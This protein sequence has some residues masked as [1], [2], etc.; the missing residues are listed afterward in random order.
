MKLTGEDLKQITDS[1]LDRLAA[2]QLLSFTKRLLT[3]SKELMD[4]LNQNPNNSSR[5]P[6]SAAPWESQSN[7]NQLENVDDSENPVVDDDQPN[8]NKDDIADKEEEIVSKKNSH[9]EVNNTTLSDEKSLCASIDSQSTLPP[10][11]NKRSAGKQIGAPGFGR[12]QEFPITSVMYHYISC[13]ALCSAEQ[14]LNSQTAWTA[15]C[16][17]DIAELIS[18]Q[19]GIIVTNTKHVFYETNC[20]CGHHNKTKPHVVSPDVNWSNTNISEWRLIGPRL[21]AMIVLLSK[22]YRNS[23]RLIREFLLEFL[24]IELSVGAIDQTIREAGRCVAPLEAQLIEAL[25]K[26]ALVYVDET[27]WKQSGKLFWLWVF[28]AAT[29]A[30][31]A[32]GKRNRTILLNFLLNGAFNG[33]LMSDGWFV[34]RDY[35]NRLRCWAHLIRKARGLAESHNCEI[36]DVGKKMLALFIKFQNAIYDMRDKILQNINSVSLTIQLAN[37][38]EELKALCVAYQECKHDKLKAFSRELLHDWDIIFR[39]LHDP[40]LPL[41]NNEAER[42]LRHWVIDRR[43]SHGTRTPEGT[44]TFSLLA[45]VIATCRIR[46]APIW[47]YLTSVIAAA[48]VGSQLPV[49]PIMQA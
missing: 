42:M 46:G 7:S 13:C 37:E 28:K 25:E 41:T 14:T 38:I 18:G 34:Y 1:S 45:S 4:R 5:P 31:F 15:F 27:S 47:N 17:L 30:F 11:E 49:L 3:Y 26:S 24:G 40:L 33:V 20:A 6:S 32:V 44:R 36:S 19:A 10:P 39:Q 12:A 2:E 8:D 43:L 22:R 21:A 29:V 9:S 16:S 35:A 48:R 23:R